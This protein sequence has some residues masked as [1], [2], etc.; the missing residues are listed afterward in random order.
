MEQTALEAEPTAVKIVSSPRSSPS[1]DSNSPTHLRSESAEGMADTTFAE[2]SE[3]ELPAIAARGSEQAAVVATA[4]E[5]SEAQ[6]DTTT[7]DTTATAASEGSTKALLNA[8]VSEQAVSR[9]AGMEQTALEAAPTAEKPDPSSS[10]DSKSPALWR[11]SE[12]AADMAATA[13]AA[14]SEDEAPAFEQA[15]VMAAASNEAQSDTS[16]GYKA[17]A[18][19]SPSSEKAVLEAA[20]SDETN[21]RTAGMEQTALE[22]ERPEP[23]A[24]KIVSSPRSS[25]SPDSNSP[26]HLRSE[27]AEGMADT[28]FAEYSEQELPA[29]AARGSE[30]AI[31]EAQLDSEEAAEKAS[32]V[33][34][35]YSV[36]CSDRAEIKVSGEQAV[37]EMAALGTQLDI[38]GTVRVGSVDSSEDKDIVTNLDALHSAGNSIIYIKKCNSAASDEA[39]PNFREEVGGS[40]V[41]TGTEGGLKACRLVVVPAIR[42]SFSKKC[43]IDNNTYSRGD[44]IV[45]I[46]LSNDVQSSGS[47][48]CL[49]TK[50][51]PSY[52]LSPSSLCTEIAFNALNETGNVGETTKNNSKTIEFEDQIAIYWNSQGQRNAE[53]VTSSLPEHRTAINQ[54][55]SD[56]FSE[57]VQDKA[58]H[59][60]NQMLDLCLRQPVLPSNQDALDDSCSLTSSGSSRSITADEKSGNRGKSTTEAHNHHLSSCVSPYAQ[61]ELG[62]EAI[63]SARQRSL[64]SS[65]KNE[66]PPITVSG[67]LQSVCPVKPYEPSA[68]NRE[69]SSSNPPQ[70]KNEHEQLKFESAEHIDICGAEDKKVC[71][72]Q[73]ILQKT[74]KKS[75]KSISPHGQRVFM[76]TPKT[77]S[78]L[79]VTGPMRNIRALQDTIRIEAEQKAEMK[80]E[81][82][83]ERRRLSKIK[84]HTNA[85]REELKRKE[86]EVLNAALL[87]AVEK[88][89]E[90]NS[91]EANTQIGL[92]QQD[93]PSLPA[94][95]F[96]AVESRRLSQTPATGLNSQDHAVDELVQHSPDE[97]GRAYLGLALKRGSRSLA[98]TCGFKSLS[99]TASK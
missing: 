26:T 62:S 41:C 87:K 7:A 36:V 82:A 29:I 67:R 47:S 28:T 81:A 13:Y 18:A 45:S 12:S 34:S 49:D 32:I 50:Q 19:V 4:S 38:K 20:V 1:P 70:I 51:S 78:F 84:Q 79:P 11:H 63:A 46:Q 90:S 77:F 93:L 71:L 55:V 74:L 60:E 88:A 22:A 98:F 21:S 39:P 95:L 85:L 76:S 68:L 59:T 5:D 89:Q 25:P 17:A 23:T 2:Y 65:Q 6:S 97:T 54:H 14:Y 64:S 35:P 3:Q 30:Q 8:A 56:H 80:N 92:S 61:M 57:D 31:F 69:V 40:D 83:C 15:A 91:H 33:S 44:M 43:N 86:L 52:S 96:S 58:V 16:T 37:S 9:T 73:L 75:G 66:L 53:R 24:E 99:L 48:A 42:E 27:S 10:S 72:P 94:Q